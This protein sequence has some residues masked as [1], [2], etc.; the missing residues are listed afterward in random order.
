MWCWSPGLRET[1]IFQDSSR[2]P[3][4][5]RRTAQYILVPV[6]ICGNRLEISSISETV[7]RYLP[8]TYNYYGVEDGITVP[9]DIFYAGND[10]NRVQAYG[11]LY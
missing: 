8:M 11:V 1:P 7:L 5:I 9:P 2:N 3:E 10:W 6:L 4:K